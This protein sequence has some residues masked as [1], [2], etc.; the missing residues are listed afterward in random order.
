MHVVYMDIRW[1]HQMLA[2][3]QAQPGFVSSLG[4]RLATR[5]LW[6]FARQGQ[7]LDKRHDVEMMLRLSG[8]CAV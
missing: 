5:A 3:G 6:L 7:P 1:L 8:E 4:P 2:E